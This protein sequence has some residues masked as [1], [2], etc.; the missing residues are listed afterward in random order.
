MQLC[1]IYNVYYFYRSTSCSSC[2]IKLSR[3]QRQAVGIMSEPR[4]EIVEYGYSIFTYA[5]KYDTEWIRAIEQLK[6]LVTRKSVEGQQTV[7]AVNYFPDES[8][9]Q[10][11]GY[12]DYADLLVLSSVSK[13]WNTLSS[14]DDLWNQL[15]LTKFSVSPAAIKARRGGV[16]SKEIYKEMFVTLMFV[17]RRVHGEHLRMDR[18][19]IMPT[20]MYHSLVSVH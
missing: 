20:Y 5:R 6:R 18:Q 9:Y 16:S 19:P 15:L 7:P 8:I 17:L 2:L 12:L 10:V 4:G 3:S 11:M 13:N 14:K 1:Y